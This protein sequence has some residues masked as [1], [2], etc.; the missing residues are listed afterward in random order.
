MLTKKN[1]GFT[2]LEMLAV[3][4]IIALIVGGIFTG[5]SMIRNAQMQNVLT[6]Y[7]QYSTA[8]KSFQ[9]K[10][11]AMPGDYA[12]AATTFGAATCT[13]SIAT[14]APTGTLSCNGNGDGYIAMD[15]M[16]EHIAAWR[17]LGVSG[18]ISGN[19]SG[20]AT[21]GDCATNMN[22]KVGE[23]IPASKLNAAGWNIAVS[24]YNA[25]SYSTGNAGVYIPM[26]LAIDHAKEHFLRVGGAL[27]DDAGIDCAQSQVPV[28]TAEEAYQIDLKNDDGAVTTGRI[29][30]MFN[31]TPTL[32]NSCNSGAAATGGYNITAAG[33]NCALAFILD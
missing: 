19:Y 28:L 10:Y 13:A 11:Q 31:N 3:I 20:M 9:S 29:R 8:I 23:N 5:R 30:G 24:T 25:T 1:A 22:I 4:T 2:L 14:A 7:Q 26:S 17:Q 16:F 33:M 15:S 12:S 21:T 18:F 6:E 32:Y 27:Q